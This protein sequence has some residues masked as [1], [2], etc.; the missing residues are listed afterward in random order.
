MTIEI[1]AALVVL[2]VIFLFVRRLAARSKPPAQAPPIGGVPLA[3]RAPSAA[4]PERASALLATCARP[5]AD[6][7][8]KAVVQARVTDHEHADWYLVLSLTGCRLAS[9]LA[10]NAALSITT[11]SKTWLDLASKRL[12]FASAAMSGRL[13]YTGDTETLMRLDDAFA[14]PPD[15]SLI[16]LE[17]TATVDG[18]AGDVDR[19][20]PADSLRTRRQALIETLKA[21]SADP[22][23]SPE[24][25]REAIAEA[26]RQNLGSVSDVPLSF[27]RVA[28]KGSSHFSEDT[29]AAVIKALSDLGPN[30][31][32]EQKLEAVRRALA[33]VP[34]A[35]P[36]L[37]MLASHGSS[38]TSEGRHGLAAR[39]VEAMLES[40]LEGLL[41]GT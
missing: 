39:L 8:L 9:G 32:R 22:N 3:P 2:M 40:A 31:T 26:V 38:T 12:S 23:V 36:F 17:S 24:E 5:R 11:N 34:D 29:R 27:Q 33:D 28:S 25:R 6:G 30:A 20:A 4:S 16:K 37:A 15:E 18:T 41:D 1:V 14:G 10:S 19:S 7:G 21:V 13:Q 35:Q